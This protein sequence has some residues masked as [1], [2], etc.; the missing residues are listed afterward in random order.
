MKITRRRVTVGLLSATVVVTMTTVTTWALA[1]D[2]SDAA[3][4]PVHLIIGYKQGFDPAS[5]TTSLSSLGAQVTTAAGW[6]QRALSELGAQTVQVSSGRSAA[7]I[8]AL[9]NDPNVAYVEV[10]RVRKATDVTPD[11]PMYTEG[12]QPELAQVNLPAAWQTTTGS[13]VKIA[14]VDTGVT[15]KGDLTG[16]VSGGY[17]FVNGDSKP[18][19]DYGHGTTVASLIAARGNN[20]AG[21]AG[22]CWQCTILPVKVLDNLGS[23]YDSTVAKGIVYAADNGAKVINLSLGGAGSTTVLSDAVAYANNKG[24]LV[25]AAA[26]N[27]GDT[28]RSYPAAYTDVV[29]VAATARNSDTRASFSNYNSSTDHWVDVSAPGDVTGMDTEGNYNTGEQGT[30]FSSPIVAGIAGLVKTVHPDY[31]G[32]SLLHA[33]QASGKTYGQPADWTNYGMV[34]AA[35]ALTIGTDTTP[36]TGTGVSPAQWTH[37]RGTV[38][39]KPTGVGDG[40]SGVRA[41]DLYADGVWKTYDRTSPYQLNYNSAGRNGNVHLQLKIYDK[42]GNVKVLDRWITADNTAPNVTITKAPKNKSKISGTVK[43]NSTATD[44]Y[45]VGKVQLLINGKVV[46]TRTGSAYTF[47]S[48]FSFAASKYPKNITVQVRAYDKVGNVK[49]STKYSYHR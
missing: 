47:K 39:I 19:D 43:I 23:G 46:S 16:A 18:D 4:P 48:S 1:S 40:W 35:K 12:L 15:V 45:A 20:G 14:V 26:G 38:A 34:D 28:V 5:A 11:D 33:V 49:Y 44:K 37:V 17:D 3:A 2:G 41:I 6:G 13:A 27:D 8:A 10:D 30:S 29:A 42:A 9:R 24:V 31:T 22:V 7:T 21:M 25:V 32:W 36:P